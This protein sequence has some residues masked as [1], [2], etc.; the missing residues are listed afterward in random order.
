MP[1]AGEEGIIGFAGP[2]DLSAE[3]R[4]SRLD[5]AKPCNWAELPRL[6]N[7]SDPVLRAL[8]PRGIVYRMGEK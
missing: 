4:T 3:D 5:L 1:F 8:A 7:L 2:E 6:D